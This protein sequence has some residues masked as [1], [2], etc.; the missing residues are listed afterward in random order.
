MI[1]GASKECVAATRWHQSGKAKFTKGQETPRS[2]V[3]AP[4][5]GAAEADDAPAMQLV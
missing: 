2:G 1:G 4:K 5:G 3:L